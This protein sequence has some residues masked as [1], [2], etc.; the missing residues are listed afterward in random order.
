MKILIVS[1][2]FYPEN[3]R[4]SDF[5]FRMV[6][7]GHE[8][9]VLTGLPNYP[10]G[11]FFGKFRIFR[12]ETIDGVK[13]Y[14]VPIIPRMESTKIGLFFNYLSFLFSGLL[15]GPILLCREKPDVIF[16]VNYSPPTASLIGLLLTKFLKAPM[17]TWVQDLWPESLSATGSVKVNFVI[18]VI[19]K[20]MLVVYSGSTIVL[21]QSKAFAEV[22]KSKGVD[23]EKI[24]YFPNWAEDIYSLDQSS[25]DRFRDLI[26]TDKFIIMFAGNL[27]V[28]QSLDTVIKAANLTKGSL[29]HWVFLGDG[30]KS[31][32]LCNAIAEYALEDSVSVLGR[33]P[34]EDMPA[35][36]NLADA[37]LVTLKTD[38][39][40]G[41]TIPG[42]IQSYLKSGKPI[43][44]A[45]DGEGAL[46]IKESGSGFNA[47]SEDFN[48]LA[49]NAI[50]MSEMTSL[51][52]SV[53]GACGQR[54][55]LQNFDAE[56][57]FSKFESFGDSR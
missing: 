3:F 50:K 19:E 6:A 25:Q 14:R 26:P 11:K 5:A 38:P 43:L 18:E 46:V 45:L 2:Y 55:Y 8:V 51:E 37:M 53:M 12:R 44:S 52:L 21:V 34:V 48:G 47:N 9:T 31:E 7:R 13:I 40:F 16:S 4:V 29:I 15:F 57:L 23:E 41:M 24:Q 20:I 30:R 28:A 27:G 33:H 17:Y 49:E 22:I 10:K 36:F 42:K 32:W 39:A 35:F 56:Y 1:P 54:F